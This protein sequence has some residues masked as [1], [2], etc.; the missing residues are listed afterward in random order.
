MKSELKKGRTE[1]GIS[2]PIELTA[3]GPEILFKNLFGKYTFAAD[4]PVAGANTHTFTLADLPAEFLDMW[5]EGLTLEGGDNGVFYTMDSCAVNSWA[6]SLASV[7]GYISSVFEVLIRDVSEDTTGETYSPSAV[8]LG[9]T[10]QQLDVSVGVD[11]SEVSIPWEDFTF[12]FI[13]G[14]RGK[15]K[16]QDEFTSKWTSGEEGIDINGT[17]KIDVSD[18][19]RAAIKDDLDNGDEF[20]TIITL[21]S[22]IMVTGSTPYSMAIDIPE[23]KFDNV[24][25]EGDGSERLETYSFMAGQSGGSAP[26]T[27][28]IV[29]GNATL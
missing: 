2:I 17:L 26:I 24:T 6:L 9:F 12:N 19:E 7:P 14:L 20:S 3:S 23:G 25:L 22:D 4:T 5:T 18:T 21:T 13:R 29:N 16:G 11:G 1:Y 10:T 15:T 28:T 8:D 27:L